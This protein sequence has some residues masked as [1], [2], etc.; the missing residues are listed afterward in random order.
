[1]AEAVDGASVV[2][3]G[4]SLEYKES[5]NCRLEA[6]YAHQQ[7]KPLIPLMMQ[8][9]YVAKGWLGLLLGTALWFKMY[10]LE[11]ADE[12][13]FEANLEPV[14]AAIAGRGQIGAK[15][16]QANISEE[17]STAPPQ[18]TTTT[19]AAVRSQPPQQQPELISSPLQHQRSGAGG[20]VSF[21]EMSEFIKAQQV[22]LKAE[23]AAMQAEIKTVRK[24]SCFLHTCSCT[25][26][27]L[28]RCRN[29]QF[30][31]AGSGQT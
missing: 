2:L 1:M 20:G 7:Q 17:T 6:N 23:R 3:F 27:I 15:A 5:A 8:R 10:N 28:D 26:T 13:T 25:I 31:K 4:V 19:T 29:D 9:G 21:A 11:D 30:T 12:Q 22:E 16:P 18:T 24:W 14:V